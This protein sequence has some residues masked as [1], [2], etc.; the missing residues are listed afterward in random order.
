MN[1]V[2]LNRFNQTAA[3]RSQL[4][5][6]MYNYPSVDVQDKRRKRRKC[7]LLAHEVVAIYECLEQQK[8]SHVQTAAKFN[9]KRQLVQNLVAAK[10]RDAKY[11]EKQ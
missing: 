8:M 9:I 6:A 1:V 7:D 3:R 11:V 4:S 10:K 5:R 2:R